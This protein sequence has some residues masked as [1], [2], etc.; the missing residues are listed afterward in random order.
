MSTTASLANFYVDSNG[1]EQP[2]RYKAADL[3]NKLA[4]EGYHWERKHP[5]DDD[6]PVRFS[7]AL[8]SEKNYAGSYDYYICV[9]NKEQA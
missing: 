5:W 3:V 4:P 6:S 1:K 7:M 8:D 9:A 2:I